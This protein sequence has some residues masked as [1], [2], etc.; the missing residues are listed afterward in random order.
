MI[1]L[2]IAFLI[3]F[4]SSSLVLLFS[5]PEKFL[6]ALLNG[7]NGAVT[8]SITLISVYAV[9]LGFL[10]VMENCGVLNCFSRLFKPLIS[11]L[12]K[13]KDEK[14]QALITLNATA[15]MLGM[16]GAATPAGVSAMARLDEIKSFEYSKA[17]LFIINTASLQ[18]LP[19]T[20][21]ALRTKFGAIAP[22][23]IIL[24]VLLSGAV[25]LVVGVILVKLFYRIKK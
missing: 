16:G 9:W 4:L 13:V 22:Y 21:I 1:F 5:A 2:N 20:I 15:N 17:M 3:V 18:L 19:T 12:F 8:L 24:P 23:D 7:A 10:K 6:P 14:A 11:K 25:A